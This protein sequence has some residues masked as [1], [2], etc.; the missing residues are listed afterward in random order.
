[1][2]ET[3]AS[4]ASNVEPVRTC[5]NCGVVVGKDAPF[6]H[7]PRCLLELGFVNALAPEPQRKSPAGRLQFGDYE[8]IEQIGRGGMGV[9]YKARQISLNRTVALKMVLDSHLASP[10]V[11]RRFLIE[12]EAAA[13]LEHPNI[14]PI[15]DISEI[16]GQHFFSMRLIEGESLERKIALGDYEVPKRGKSRFGSRDKTQE[17]IAGLIAT[18]AR[19]VDYAHERGVLHRDLKPSNILIDKE[20]KPHLTDFGLA[21][22]ADKTLA[23]TPATTVLGTPGYMAPEQAMG[24]A[25]QA[26]GDIY[27]LG[28]IFYEL[29]TGKPPFDGPTA[30]E[31]L[32]R[33]KEEEA[34]NPRRKN[35]AIDDDLVTICLKC[36]E[37][38]PA[39][40]YVSANALAEDLERWFRHETIRARR[41]S[42]VRRTSRWV[43]RNPV[44]SALI[45][46]LCV[47]LVGALVLL[48]KLS[49][50]NEFASR[51]QNAALMDVRMDQ[52]WGSD[53]QAERVPSE[54]LA[55]ITGRRVR[56][57][58]SAMSTRY[59]M[60][61][62][63]EA[64]PS[65]RVQKFA[66][67]IG[68]IEEEL[69]RRL[70]EPVRLD[71]CIY[72]RN[73]EAVNDLVHGK[74]DFLRIGGV[75]YLE[76]KALSPGIMPIATQ[77][78][79]KRAIIFARANAG[80]NSV[81]DLKTRS[82][83]FGESYATISFWAK[84]YLATNGITAA[85][86]DH[87]EL[88]DAVALFEEGVRSGSINSSS[89]VRLNSH[90]E[91][92]KAVLDGRFDAGVASESNL[93]EAL[94]YRRVTPLME[95]QSTSLFWLARSGLKERLV[96][97]MQRAFLHFPDANALQAFGGAGSAFSAV[98]YKEIE[99]IQGAIKVVADSFPE[100]S[101]DERPIL[102]GK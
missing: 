77:A 31:I 68:K 7:C 29:L 49:Q 66:P 99:A 28:A 15:H 92:V 27:S 94:F 25:S 80:I 20:S 84:Y 45:A 90:V 73:Q 55:L 40:R 2:K 39:Q 71:L 22:I 63:V 13:K 44:G 51:G 18:I 91:V 3:V 24:E 38:D 76:A 58:G 72:K 64:D 86:L 16:E 78:P 100:R 65:V 14:V 34:V 35:G 21:K 17:K 52:F 89:L 5:R 8:L 41:T 79:A 70:G 82:F 37:K 43:Q 87:Y 57:T 50:A 42:I 9:V 6:G 98:P 48:D 67:I 47:S 62:L 59:T 81:V 1:M 30:M 33:T 101:N 74:L 23:L 32:R 10:V 36:L 93:R 88:L 85:Q 75:S 69:G 96:K 56:A 60:A 11:L 46:T 97:E 19:A 83:A 26:A 61:F 53:Q 4:T 102:G 54:K 95:F 12:A